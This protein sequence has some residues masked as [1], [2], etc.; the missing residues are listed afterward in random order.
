[1]EVSYRTRTGRVFAL[2]S[3]AVFVRFCACVLLCVAR[4]QRPTAVGSFF[5]RI[6]SADRGRGRGREGKGKGAGK[7]GGGRGRDALDWTDRQAVWDV[8]LSPLAA[9]RQRRKACR[10][11]SGGLTGA[12]IAHTVP[13][14]TRQWPPSAHTDRRCSSHRC[15]N[16]R[17][18][19]TGCNSSHHGCRPQPPLL[20]A[21]HPSH[22]LHNH[23]R[24]SC[25]LPSQLRLVL[26]R[27]ECR[28]Q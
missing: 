5:Q 27:R 9:Q 19:R 11:D 21:L 15:S 25:P 24:P 22:P 2:A 12:L 4:S 28:C 6:D 16:S 26:R 10:T 3:S 20:L 18:R 8:L 13:A 1:M 23:R 14:L 7:R 17:S